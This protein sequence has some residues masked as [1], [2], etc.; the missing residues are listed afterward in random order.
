MQVSRLYSDCVGS[1]I[2]YASEIGPVREEGIIGLYRNDAK[3]I[4]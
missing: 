4:R 2:L 1:A 3:V